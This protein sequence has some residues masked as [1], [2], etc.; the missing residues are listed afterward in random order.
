MSSR[1]CT[2]AK[3]LGLRLAALAAVLA[4]AGCASTPGPERATD[5]EGPPPPPPEAQTL[6]EQAVAAMAAGDN[7][8]AELR[9]EEF[10][11][12]YPD[13][14][15]AHVNLAILKA[16]AGDDLA[17]EASLQ[18]AL[19]LDAAHAAALNELG[20]LHRRQGRFDEAENA[21]LAAIAA[22]PGY[23]LP[24]YNLGVLNELY[25]QRLEA[26]LSHFE[27]YQALSGEDEEVD[28]WIVDLKRRIAANQRTANVTE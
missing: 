16:R 25:L 12:R 13:Y 18:A 22:D 17:A 8:E 15:G 4:L 19:A 6:Y 14:P 1:P 11:V 23:A 2:D 21:Y 7:V 27:Q 20:M 5:G 28:R 10:L 26:A 9:F 24:H 3:R